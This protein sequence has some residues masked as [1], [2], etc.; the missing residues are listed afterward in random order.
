MRRLKLVLV[1]LFLHSY[2]FTMAQSSA[3]TAY[4]N[5]ARSGGNADVSTVMN[6][7]KP[8]EILHD[9]Q[10]MAYDSMSAVRRAAY[11]LAQAA[12]VASRDAMIRQQAVQYLIRAIADDDSGNSGKAIDYLKQFNR[13]DFNRQAKDSI[14]QRFKRPVA[15]DP[16]LLKLIGYVEMHELEKDIQPLTQP[17]N[18]QRVRWTSLLALARMG[19]Q[20]ALENV[21]TRVRRIKTGDD[22]IYEI[23]PDLVYTRQK[24]AIRYMVDVMKSD[25]KDCL[26]ADAEREVPISCGYRIMEQLAPV[27]KDYPLSLDSSGDMK[28][29]NYEQ[30]LI[31]VRSWFDKHPDFTI[32]N[33]TY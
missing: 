25:S 4:V 28:T 20:A 15:S 5:T 11:A 2:F 26:S 10:Q 33:E 7:M 30:A 29:K 14:Q 3:I 1:F 9:I 12:G 19:D 8:S 23:F 16:G 17:G 21:L 6:V 27:V 22:L 32:T 31:T 13:Q 24:Q 18:T